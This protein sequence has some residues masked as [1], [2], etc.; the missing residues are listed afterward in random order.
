MSRIQSE[1]KRDDMVIAQ[2][3]KRQRFDVESDDLRLCE[4]TRYFKHL[5]RRH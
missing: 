1:T 5:P 3:L 2:E 4:A